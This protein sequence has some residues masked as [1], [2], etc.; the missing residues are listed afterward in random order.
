[1]SD[2]D[3][4]SERL[5]LKSVKQKK[6]IISLSVVSGLIFYIQ[7]ELFMLLDYQDCLQEYKYPSSQCSIALTFQDILCWSRMIYKIIVMIKITMLVMAMT[8]AVVLNCSAKGAD[9]DD[10]KRH[11]AIM[12]MTMIMIIGLHNVQQLTLCYDNYN[13]VLQS[14]PH[15]KFY[16]IRR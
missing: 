8:I 15:F 6:I 9:A 1:M 16:K 4:H 11:A 5:V 10:G 12:A 3:T 13:I 2:S 7:I 14:H